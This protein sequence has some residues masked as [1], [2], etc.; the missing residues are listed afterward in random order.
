[1]HYDIDLR[2]V[3]A[4]SF[5]MSDEETRYYLKGVNIEIGPLGVL[6]IATDGHR[7]ICAK[8]GDFTQDSV[9]SLI[10]P[11]ETVKKIKIKRSVYNALLREKSPGMWCIE[12]G[13]EF[14]AFKPV[15]A[16]FPSWRFVLPKHK[17]RGSYAHFNPEY[18]V[19][20][21]RAGAL[22]GCS[23]PAIIPNGGNPAWVSFYESAPLFGVVMPKR[24]DVSAM[25]WPAWAGVSPFETAPEKERDNIAA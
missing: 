5:A 3:K 15:E 1:M 10:I 21:T 9:T 2:S 20:F 11:A 19:D 18:L 7:L 22:Y 25:A 24:N 16:D 6:C 17:E 4:C 14:F 8:A 23:D 13:N 12:Y